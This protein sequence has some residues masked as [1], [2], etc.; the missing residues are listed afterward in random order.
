MSSSILIF[1]PFLPV[2]FESLLEDNS[3]WDFLGIISR[4]TAYAL[5][6]TNNRSITI[7]L[8]GFILFYNRKD[9]PKGKML[10]HYR[11]PFPDSYLPGLGT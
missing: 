5:R 6:L 4:L 7:Y 1:D 8:L 11:I 2:D 9:I 3:L 10:N